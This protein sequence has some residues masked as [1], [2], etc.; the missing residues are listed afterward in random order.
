VSYNLLYCL[1]LDILVL[2]KYETSNNGYGYILCIMDVFSRKAWYYPMKT[3]GLSDTTSAIKK[4]FSKSGL[5]KFNKEALVIIMSDSDSD[6]QFWT[7]NA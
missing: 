6:K 2:K 3:K 7:E 1:Q 5:H 4:F